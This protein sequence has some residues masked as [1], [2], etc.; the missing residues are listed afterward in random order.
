[1]TIKMFC[2]IKDILFSD[3]CLG[4]VRVSLGYG[5]ASRTRNVRPELVCEKLTWVIVYFCENCFFYPIDT[6]KAAFIGMDSHT[7]IQV[8]DRL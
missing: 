8:E 6:I 7:A 5:V 4:L 2:S 3:Q 1:M